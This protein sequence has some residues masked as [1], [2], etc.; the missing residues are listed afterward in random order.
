L[1]HDLIAAEKD[2][3]RALSKAL[4]NYLVASAV[5]MTL[6]AFGVD[7]VRAAGYTALL[8]SILLLDLGFV[9]KTWRWM[10][11]TSPLAQLMH[12]FIAIGF[13]AGFLF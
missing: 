10:S 3:A 1:F 12:F 4:G 7:P 9:S 8:F 5:L 6:M 13:A 11:E 2:Q